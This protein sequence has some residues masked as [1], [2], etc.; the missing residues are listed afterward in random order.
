MDATETAT[1]TRPP[2]GRRVETLDIL[3]IMESIPHRFPFL[4]I[5]RVED[6]ITDTS[7]VGVKNVTINEQFFQGH[8][9]HHPVMPGVLII[10]SMA[11]TAAV[12]VVETLGPDAMGK[13]VYFMMIEGAKFRRPVVPGDQMRIHVRKERNR[14]NVWKFSAEAK[15]DGVVVAEAT[16]AAMIM[17]K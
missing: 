11:Q 16:Y 1:G 9:P 15:V 2:S 3:R 5:D 12:L 10:E 17:D 4:L 7:A 8:F 14:G 6:V 13:V